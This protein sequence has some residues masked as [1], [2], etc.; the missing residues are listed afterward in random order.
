MKLITIHLVKSVFILA[1]VTVASFG[2]RHVRFSVHR[3][4]TIKSP[5]NA[6]VESENNPA[7]LNKVVAELDQR[8]DFASERDNEMPPEDNSELNPEQDKDIKA[9]SRTKLSKGSKG[10]EKISMGDNDNLYI[11]KE[12]EL[13]YVSKQPD[14]SVTKMQVQID[15]TT[16][17]MNIINIAGGKSEVPQLIPMGDGYNIYVTDEGQTWYVGGGS[18]SRVEVD[19]ATGEI[20]IL[21]R[22]GGDDER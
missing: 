17:E 20:T 12:G 6:E 14:G 4:G 21:E 1:M 5:V 16:G 15:Q 11:T 19:D 18:K 7:D 13:W 8:K 2:V 10:F 9:V 22:H 3:A